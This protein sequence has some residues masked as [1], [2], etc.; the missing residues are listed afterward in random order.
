MFTS[1]LLAD[2][3]N[4]AAAL[5]GMGCLTAGLLMGRRR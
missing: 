5:L 3:A 1:S 4:L 2:A